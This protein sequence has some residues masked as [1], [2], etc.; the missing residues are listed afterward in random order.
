MSE[1]DC[2]EVLINGKRY[3]PVEFSQHDKVIKLLN[4]VYSR[5]WVEAYYDPYNDQMQKFA[6]PLADYMSEINC[7]IGFKE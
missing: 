4:E 3:V 6:R 5:L 2:I 7:I 1:C